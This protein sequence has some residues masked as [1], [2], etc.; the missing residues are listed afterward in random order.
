MTVM[1][2]LYSCIHD[3]FTLQENSSETLNAAR[4]SSKSLWEEDEK[5]ISKVKEVYAKNADENYIQQKYGTI[6]WDYSITMNQFDESYLMVPV[7]KN[8]KVVH[9]LEVFREKN[10]VYFQFS[11][12]DLKSNEFFQTLIFD[13][14]KI[15]AAESS[16]ANDTFAKTGTINV[17]VCKK[18]TIIVGY[19]EGAS[20]EQ[21]PIEN[22][23]TICKFVEM[24]LPASQC[25]GLEDPA[26]GECMGGGTGTG[27]LGF[28]YPEPPEDEDPCEKIKEVVNKPT[29]QDSL[30]S[31]KAFAQASLRKERGF[32]E[33]NDGTK[34]SDQV[35]DFAVESIISVNTKGLIHVHP[36]LSIK[37]FAPMD[38]MTFLDVLRSKNNGNIS[39]SYSGMVSAFG[40][41][42][43]SFNGTVA[44]LPSAILHQGQLDLYVLKLEK[45]YIK[46]YYELLKLE[47]KPRYEE[48]SPSGKQKLFFETIKS[49]GLEGKI[50]LIEEENG[51]TSPII[52]DS[53]GTPMK[54]SSC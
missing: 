38:I 5:Y 25:L 3:D 52:P 34:V 41:Y 37:M 49:M 39:N 4:F 20:G 7:L 10:R 8:N 21:Y 27:N 15:K 35:R 30:N 26:T 24:A 9:I 48:L 16:N 54:Q 12:D 28:E 22:T 11:A 44:D 13:R 45:I 43:I 42:F 1:L 53:N 50:N 46:T 29:I 47:N 6:F 18:Y 51:T 36:L 33:L 40:T 19:V 32:Q 23:K 17:S 14:G 2:S 31:M